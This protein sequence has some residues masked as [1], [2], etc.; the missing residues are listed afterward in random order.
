MGDG[1]QHAVGGVGERTTLQPDV[2]VDAEPGEGGDLFPAQPGHPPLAS[3]HGQPGR[4]GADPRP[5]RG[6]ELLN[7]AAMVHSFTVSAG[8][9]VGEDFAIPP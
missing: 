1:L 8:R 9:D 7:L 4:L 2:V 3:G 6:Q 5:A